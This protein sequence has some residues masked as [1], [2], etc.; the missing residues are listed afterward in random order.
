MHSNRRIEINGHVIEE[1]YWNSRMVVYVDNQ[2]VDQGTYE[3][4]VAQIEDAAF[5]E[6]CE[7]DKVASLHQTDLW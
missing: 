7:R 1:F 5:A 3:T 6:E 2:R 4:E